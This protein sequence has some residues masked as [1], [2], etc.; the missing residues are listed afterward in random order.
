LIKD[1]LQV[2]K[3]RFPDSGSGPCFWKMACR[4]SH[5]VIAAGRE[6]KNGMGIR[7]DM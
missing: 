7:V 3:G 1:T 5:A 2:I 4:E 6:E